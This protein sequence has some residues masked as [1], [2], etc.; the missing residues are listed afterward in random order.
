M[1]TQR[2]LT[3]DELI[4]MNR[5]AIN[6]ADITLRVRMHLKKFLQEYPTSRELTEGL[7]ELYQPPK[8]VLRFPRCT[9]D[10]TANEK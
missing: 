9:T 7:D 4:Q 5:A 8:P 1:R 10:P 6:S 2:E 3:V